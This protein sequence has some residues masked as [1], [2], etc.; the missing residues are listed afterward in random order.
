MVVV[1][2]PKEDFVIRANLFQL[3]T[4]KSN[5]VLWGRIRMRRRILWLGGCEADF[6]E[7]GS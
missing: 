7:K 1:G 5:T 2:L 6:G 4:G 3:V